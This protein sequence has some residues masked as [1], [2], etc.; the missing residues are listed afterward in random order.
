MYLSQICVLKHTCIKPNTLSSEKCSHFSS[1]Q[2]L[3]FKSLQQNLKGI[4]WKK[5]LAEKDH[6]IENWTQNPSAHILGSHVLRVKIKVRLQVQCSLWQVMG[7]K[8]T[9]PNSTIAVKNLWISRG[10]RPSQGKKKQQYQLVFNHVC[11]Q[12]LEW[13]V[14]FWD[15]LWVIHS[16][17]LHQALVWLPSPGIIVTDIPGLLSSDSLYVGYRYVCLW[18][19]ILSSVG[20]PETLALKCKSR[21]MAGTFCPKRMRVYFDFSFIQIL[22]YFTEK[23]YWWSRIMNS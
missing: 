7:N 14:Y 9:N 1:I 10:I 16:D 5:C 4:S 15:W 11:K 19:I 3:S 20:T 17:A 18:F 8:G 22:S 23:K 13:R 6:T 12:S 2:L 21:K